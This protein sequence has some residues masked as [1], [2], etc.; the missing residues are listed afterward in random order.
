MNTATF[1]K[2]TEDMD[3]AGYGLTISTDRSVWRI[4]QGGRQIHQNAPESF[5]ILIGSCDKT[6]MSCRIE[7][8]TIPGKR[9]VQSR[10]HFVLQDPCHQKAV[11][12]AYHQSDGYLGYLGT[13]HTHPEASPKPSTVDIND[14][15][16][17]I[18]RNPDRQLYFVIVGIEKTHVFVKQGKQFKKLKELGSNKS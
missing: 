3:F 12:Q 11:N 9:D 17:C 18:E 1:A 10:S 14:W 6:S 7:R 15:L 4:W 5:G 2:M 13:W 8:A 16:A